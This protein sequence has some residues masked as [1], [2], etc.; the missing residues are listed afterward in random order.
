MQTPPEDNCL[1]QTT[2]VVNLPGLYEGTIVPDLFGE[3]AIALMQGK[4]TLN[5]H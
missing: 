2:K 3:Q 5:D 1:T 4:T